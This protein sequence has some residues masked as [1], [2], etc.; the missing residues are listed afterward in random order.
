MNMQTKTPAFPL[1]ARSRKVRRPA[2]ALAM[3]TLMVSSLGVAPFSVAVVRAQGA[4]AQGN[5]KLAEGSRRAAATGKTA[6][7]Q[8]AKTNVAKTNVAKTNVAK[9]NV[10]ESQGAALNL[11]VGKSLALAFPDDARYSVLQGQEFVRTEV[12]NGLLLLDGL[13]IGE[14][15][16]VVDSPM[17]GTQR[18]VLKMSLS[19]AAQPVNTVQPVVQRVVQRVVQP[20]SGT[21]RSAAKNLAAA[22]ALSWIST[23]GKTTVIS[24]ARI[25]NQVFASMIERRAVP[26]VNV[27][28][29]AQL[30]PFRSFLRTEKAPSLPLILTSSNKTIATLPAGMEALEIPDVRPPVKAQ[31][32]PMSAIA[33]RAVEASLVQLETNNFE[34]PI[35]ISPPVALPNV[36]LSTVTILTQSPLPANIQRVVNDPSVNRPQLSVS[37]GM[38]RVLAFK[39][40]ILSVFFSDENV[41]DA[42]AVN[43][44]TLAVTGKGVGRSTLAIFLAQ[45]PDDVV[46]KAKIYNIDVYSPNA[47]PVI[48]QNEI[49]DPVAAQSAITTALADPRVSVSVFQ[50][51]NSDLVVRLTGTLRDKAEIDAAVSTATLFVPSVI[52]S[53]FASTTALSLGDFV[54]GS[55]LTSEGI[56]QGKLRNIFSNDSIEL[57]ALPGST[58]LKANVDSIQEAERILALLPTLD[59]RIQPFIVIRGGAESGIYNP[60]TPVLYGEDYEMTRTLREVTGISTVYVKRTARNALAIYGSVRSRADYDRIRRYAIILPQLQDTAASQS[61]TN[62]T[63]AGTPL[64]SASATTSISALAPALATA[65]GLAPS[66]STGALS[67]LTDSNAP[68]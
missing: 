5:A 46:G 14:V 39:Q 60:E 55:A 6:E 43:A 68:A 47:A 41:M 33:I 18:F 54:N 27:L 23:S 38:A 31:A 8:V 28:S 42:R 29:F 64:A 10:A 44:R 50:K 52:S 53:L 19:G 2:A 45:S 48:T 22:P 65:N 25:P 4:Q 56:L 37:Q 3:S 51:P 15:I 36:P 20:N 1:K 17:Q 40:N 35:E 26:R 58:A 9:T 34:A 66:A 63:N 67:G 62:T 13:Q 57:V 61:T 59:R 16:L 7:T 11:R 24:S 30:A 49:T 32:A 12:S 21:T